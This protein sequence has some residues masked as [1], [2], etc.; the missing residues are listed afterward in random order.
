MR[1]YCIAQGTLLNALWWQRADICTCIAD[2][3][4]SK[5]AKTTLYSTYTGGTSGKEST[6]SA[7]D[8]GSV[9]GLGRSPGGGNGNPLQYSWL[10]NSMG[11]G[12]WWTTVHGLKKSQTWLRDG[13]PNENLKNHHQQCCSKCFKVSALS[14]KL[15]N[16][17]KWLQLSAL[18]CLYDK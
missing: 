3:L 14:I 6:F 16:L 10:E 11:R 15:C 9:P 4:C 8:G 1:T 18:H 12:V 5:Q 17:S 7:G 2:S 13:C